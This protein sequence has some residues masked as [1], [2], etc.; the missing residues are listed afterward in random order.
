MIVIEYLSTKL[1]S[2]EKNQTA[3]V[4]SYTFKNGTAMHKKK[5]I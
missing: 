3:N 2:T 5:T 1:I 4:S